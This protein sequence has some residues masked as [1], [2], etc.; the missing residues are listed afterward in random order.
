MRYPT[1]NTTEL[2]CQAL[3]WAKDAAILPEPL[4]HLLDKAGWQYTCTADPANLPDELSSAKLDMLLDLTH[5]PHMAALFAR[6]SDQK[7][8]AE[9]PLLVY[10]T[11]NSHND[12]K[13]SPADLVISSQPNHIETQ[14]FNTMLSI[15]TENRSLRNRLQVQIETAKGIEQLKNAIV[16]NVAHELRTPLLQVKG[17]ITLLR[18]DRHDQFER[19]IDLAQVATSRLELS[20]HN[21]TL[22][23]K[24]INDSLDQPEFAPFHPGEAAES[25][26]RH[27][28]R[29]W[30]HREGIQY[31]FI[32]IEPNLPSVI[33]DRHL[34]TIALQQLLDNALKF[35]E[36]RPIILSVTPI[37]NGVHFQI[38]D[39]G[40][41]IDPS[42]HDLIFD[43]FYQVDSSSTR[44]Y[45]GIGAGLAIVQFIMERHHVEMAVKSTLGKGS[46][47]EFTLA[48]A[49]PQDQ[50]LDRL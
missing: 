36:M 24:L 39:E 19:L 30:Q 42:Q 34:I 25:A 37:Q 43:W 4:S 35:G 47:F 23:N 29:L 49:D 46:C 50:A 10:V 16:R 5:D 41:G 14:V 3:W 44:N 45:G 8:L 1:A 31:L 7:P 22:L 6:L 20:V 13:N 48:L 38:C 18:D 9:R 33:G 17:A 11:E 32:K 15:R 2:P 21:I 40:I 26:V 27:I 28:R 12:Y